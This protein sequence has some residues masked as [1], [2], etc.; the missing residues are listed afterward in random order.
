MINRRVEMVG[1][2]LRSRSNSWSR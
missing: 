1:W 2:Q